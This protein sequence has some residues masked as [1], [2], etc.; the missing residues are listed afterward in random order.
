[1]AET[2]SPAAQS[3]VS[4]VLLRKSQIQ[5]RANPSSKTNAARL[6][7]KTRIIQMRNLAMKRN[8]RAEVAVLDKQLEEILATI[9][10]DPNFKEREPEVADIMAKVNERNR[11]ANQEAMRLAAQADAER[12][13]K[14]RQA[15]LT[16]AGNVPIDPSARLK[17]VPRMFASRLVLLRRLP[18]SDQTHL[19]LLMVVLRALKARDTRQCYSTS[20]Y[21]RLCLPSSGRSVTCKSVDQARS[22]GRLYVEGSREYRG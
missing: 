6:L 12:R 18:V 11:K 1:M 21:P 14:E 15:A 3:D 2:I 10:A 22:Q 20:H 7:E 19:F 4:A 9:A 16:G 13:R 17:T 8:D 5:E